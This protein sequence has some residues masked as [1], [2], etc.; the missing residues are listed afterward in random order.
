MQFDRTVADIRIVNAGS[1]GMPF[2]EPGAYWL[3][4]GRELE[5]RRS[6]YDLH[7][8]AERLRA[9]SY[10]QAEEFASRNVL[11]PPTAREMIELFARNESDLER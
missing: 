2:G 5:L 9:T 6:E 8:A 1:V 11:R 7:A 10:P 4:I 3:L